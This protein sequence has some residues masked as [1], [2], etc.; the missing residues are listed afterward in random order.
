M[1]GPGEWRLS[2]L[3]LGRLVAPD[4]RRVR[5]EGRPLAALAFLALQGPTMRSRLAGL[6]W[7]DNTESVARNNLVQLLRR[8]AAACGT[9]LVDPH[10]PLTLRD[11]VRTDVD[12]LVCAFEGDE[13]EVE[14]PDHVLLDGLSFP[15]A[16]ELQDWLRAQRERLDGLRARHLMR[17]AQ[18]KE[19]QGDWP[20]ALAF[21][22]RALHFDPVSEDAYR[23]LMRLH[24]LNGDP[25]AARAAYERCADVLRTELHTEPLPETRA[26]AEDILRGEAVAHVAP[27]RRQ[28]PR[29]ALRPPVLLGRETAWERMEKGWANG[30][31]IFVTGEPGM[32]KTRL[33]ADFAASKGR[34]LALEGRPGDDA[35]PFTAT[36]RNVRRILDANPDVSLDAWT[37]DALQPLVPELGDVH[38]V[39]AQLGAR[40]QDA[41]GAVFERG[42]R[43][44]DVLTVD[45]MQYCDLATIEAGF[46]LFGSA[47]PLGG[48]S[49]IP[50]VLA[51]YRR[52]ELSPEAEAFVQQQVVAGKAVLIELDAL[53]E[54]SVHRLLGDL[55]VPELVGLASRLT[56]FSNGNPQFLL[57]AVKHLVETNGVRPHADTLPLPPKVGEVLTRRLQQLSVP[58]LQT[59]RAA[60]VLQSDFTLDLVAEVLGAPLLTTASAW[61]ELERAQIMNGERFTHDLVYEALVAAIPEAVRKLLHRSAARVLTRHAASPGRVARHWLIGGEH[62]RAAPLLLEAGVEAEATSR[63]QEAHDFYTLA[64][65]SYDAIGDAAGHASASSA[66]GKVQ[67]RL[68]VAASAALHA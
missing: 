39:R 54:A 32:G 8:L 53:D 14:V 49:G 52:G 7:P 30:Q 4:G 48:A 44:V 50:H 65:T 10:D 17:R 58:A 64:M 36:A 31:L 22:R 67:E 68:T 33:V 19:V 18:R 38:G 55:D 2:L 6:L 15:E 46:I 20:N 25:A 24:Y 59:A 40:L 45:D 26:L 51:A 16:H 66:R 1:T 37:R 60:A 23:R 29:S 62:A 47:F 13:E 27:P 56:R 12:V 28:V 43:H 63:W 42:L 5:C 21:T 9:D 61:E 57:E 11:I 34:V 35:A 3:G 41:V